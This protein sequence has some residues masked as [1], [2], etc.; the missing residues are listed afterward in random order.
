MDI[1]QQEQFKREFFRNYKFR[2]L[3]L[4]SAEKRK[5]AD[6]S[7]IK[8][9]RIFTAVEQMSVQQE[10]VRISYIIRACISGLYM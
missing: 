4:R 8:K 10:S 2:Y 1:S 6:C 5:Y 9:D 3:K 7:S